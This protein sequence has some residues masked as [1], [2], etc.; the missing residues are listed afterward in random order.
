MKMSVHHYVPT[1]ISQY[2]PT[3]ISQLRR[4]INDKYIFFG[5]MSWDSAAKKILDAEYEDKS[6]QLREFIDALQDGITKYEAHIEGEV[7][8]DGRDKQGANKSIANWKAILKKA[9]EL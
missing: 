9:K 8:M 5:Q 3:T 6:K 4:Y 1:T 7:G 2:V